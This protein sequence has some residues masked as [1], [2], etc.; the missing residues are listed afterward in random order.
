MAIAVINGRRVQVP[1]TLSDEELRQSG[2]IKPGRTLVRREKSGNFV[3]PRGSRVNVNDGDV[4]VDS[5]SR[6]KG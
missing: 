6:I 5:P 4:F 1:D 3:I 2:G